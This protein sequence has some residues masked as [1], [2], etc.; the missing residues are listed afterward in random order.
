MSTS[1]ELQKQVAQREEYLAFVVPAIEKLVRARGKARHYERSSSTLSTWS[2]DN[3]NGFT[4]EVQS[5]IYHLGDGNRIKVWS[6][7]ADQLD[8]LLDVFYSIELDFK[9]QKTKVKMASQ[10]RVAELLRSVL[11]RWEEIARKIDQDAETARQ[12]DEDLKQQQARENEIRERAVRLG[13]TL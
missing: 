7:P 1:H 3:F 5:G 10:N 8:E 6:G 2:L 4:F 12:R 13:F 11:E 9:D